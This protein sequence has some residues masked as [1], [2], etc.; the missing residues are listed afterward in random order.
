[1]HSIT[2]VVLGPTTVN[3][4]AEALGSVTGGSVT[5]EVV[6]ASRV[7]AGTADA[8]VVAAA[9][10]APPVKDA[11]VERTSVATTLVV[12]SRVSV[13]KGNDEVVASS[14]DGKEQM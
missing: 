13:L 5:T 9:A 11:V 8:V 10:K 14:E 6:V 1:M 12:G 7:V 2:A 3:G 4:V